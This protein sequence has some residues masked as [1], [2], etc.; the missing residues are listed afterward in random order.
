MKERQGVR[1]HRMQALPTTAMPKELDSEQSVEAGELLDVYGLLFVKPPLTSQLASGP[2]WG[3]E[4]GRD[5]RVVQV[6]SPY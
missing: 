3:F 2:G 4:G 1:L 6:I 5:N